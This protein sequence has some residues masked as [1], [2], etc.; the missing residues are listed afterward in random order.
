MT[1]LTVVQCWAIYPFNPIRAALV[2]VSRGLVGASFG[3]VGWSTPIRSTDP[4]AEGHNT[5]RWQPGRY[6]YQLAE[7]GGMWRQAGPSRR[8]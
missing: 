4:L 6:R 5:H 2:G 7:G 8:P 1:K 3:S